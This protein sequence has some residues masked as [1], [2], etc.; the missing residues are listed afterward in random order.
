MPI[1]EWITD[2]V[3]LAHWFNDLIESSGAVDPVLEIDYLAS[4]ANEVIALV[5]GRQMIAFWDGS[6]LSFQFSVYDMQFDQYSFHY[7]RQDGSFVWRYDLH[8]G[9]EAED[10]TMSHVHRPGNG[11]DGESRSPHGNVDLEIVL[12]LIR[13]DQAARAQG[14]ARGETNPEGAPVVE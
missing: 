11:P 1:P 8:P 6:Y 3:A 10:G 14:Q 2:H 12:E 4:P 13:E 5:A 7:A 9:H